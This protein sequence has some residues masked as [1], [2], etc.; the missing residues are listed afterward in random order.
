[1]VLE[2]M[3]TADAFVMTAVI[4]ST[5]QLHRSPRLAG[6]LSSLAPAGE[7]AAGLRG[8]GPHVLGAAVVG[9]CGAPA[10]LSG[11]PRSTALLSL[12]SSPVPGHLGPD[13]VSLQ[14]PSLTDLPPGVGGR[15]RHCHLLLTPT[16]AV[17][18]FPAFVHAGP[19]AWTRF[20]PAPGDPCVP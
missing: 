3:I 15:R 10:C 1:M 5:P 12:R 18:T 13:S 14:A 2:E 8:Q 6:T 20:V 9:V 19:S 11:S 7:G 17:F 4:R 16:R